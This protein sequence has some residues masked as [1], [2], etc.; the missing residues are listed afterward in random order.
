M[1]MN[2]MA[3]GK[4]NTMPPKDYKGIL[5][6]TPVDTSRADWWSQLLYNAIP[7][8]EVRT[9]G[10]AYATTRLPGE[11]ELISRSVGTKTLARWHQGEMPLGS[12]TQFSE[13]NL[14][15]PNPWKGFKGEYAHGSVFDKPKKYSKEES[16]FTVTDNYF[17]INPKTKFGKNLQD[18]VDLSFSSAIFHNRKKP[19][20]DQGGRLMFFGYDELLNDIYFEEDGSFEDLWNYDLDEGEKLNSKANIGRY[21]FAKPLTKNRP[22]VRVKAT[23]RGYKEGK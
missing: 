6:A 23:Y 19:N 22:I 17:D 12:D 11:S 2:I 9:K 10:K 1:N 18:R 14:K 8:L 21:L 13:K 20:P 5:K 3:E 7:E 15:N 16:P 4:K